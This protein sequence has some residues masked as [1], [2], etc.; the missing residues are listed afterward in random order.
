VVQLGY[1]LGERVEMRGC[2]VTDCNRKHA[3]RGLCRNH[4]TQASVRG[5]RDNHPR[6]D[7]LG[8]ECSEAGC[9]SPTK[10]KGLCN[11][12][13]IAARR[14]G[15]SGTPT[16]K[17]L[18][19][20]RASVSL[21]VCD[22]HYQGQRMRDKGI[23]ARVLGDYCTLLGFK[24]HLNSQ[25]YWSRREGDSRG[26]RIHILQ[27]RAVLEDHLKRKL[28]PGENVH[29]VNGDRKDNRIENLEIWSTSQ[30]PGQRVSDKT[31]WAVAWLEQYA[32]ERLS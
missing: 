23:K 7:G 4:Y 2:S 5:E 8:L 14:G 31:A 29:H 21:G 19:C 26:K 22:K 9:A 27:H 16:C 24:W 6:T 10:A 25:G 3:A 32:P 17:V 11:T 1:R 20:N 28:A 15:G 30:P 13:Y 12:H 18:D